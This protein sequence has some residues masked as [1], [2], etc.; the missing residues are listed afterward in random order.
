MLLVA[1]S[2][3]IVLVKIPTDLASNVARGMKEILNFTPQVRINEHVVI[4]Q[5]V[6]V[7]E[8][9]TIS[10][11]LSVDYTWSHEW[12][13]STKTLALRGTFTAKAGFDLHEPFSVD[14]Q[15]FP[16][17]VRATMPAPKILSVQM[18]TYNVLRDEDGWWNKISP[19]DRENAVQELQRV[20]HDKAQSSGMLDEARLSIEQRIREIVEQN[21]APVEFIYPWQER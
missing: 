10:R 12:L 13:G 21:S 15:K 14:I 19:G 6:P 20:A 7:A 16:L 4:E 18:N 11:D 5:S 3:Y 9:A 1:L 8:L 2:M 17:K